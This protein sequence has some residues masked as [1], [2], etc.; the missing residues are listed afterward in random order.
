MQPEIRD[1]WERF[2]AGE[3]DLNSVKHTAPISLPVLSK[4]K[5]QACFFID[6]VRRFN[7]RKFW[8]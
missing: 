6:R 8:L 2:H 7:K 5:K 3:I 4:R 1:C